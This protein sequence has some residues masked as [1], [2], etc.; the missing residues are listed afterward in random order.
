MCNRGQ[1]HTS[2]LETVNGRIVPVVASGLQVVAQSIKY[3]LELAWSQPSEGMELIFEGNSGL[4]NP[5]LQQ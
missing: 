3:Y 2:S 1:V 4:L 5:D